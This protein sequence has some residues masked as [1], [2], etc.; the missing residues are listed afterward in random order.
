MNIIAV[1]QY[2]DTSITA[3]AGHGIDVAS[4]RADDLDLACLSFIKERL[5]RNGGVRAADIGCGHGGQALRMARL[6]AVV[7]CL[8]L[9]D[10]F[11]LTKKMAVSENLNLSFHI[12]D[13]L[14]SDKILTSNLTAVICQRTIHYLSYIDAVVALQNVRSLLQPSAKLFLSASG[15]NSE[16]GVGYPHANRVIHAR[17]ACLSPVVADKH[18]IHEPVCL[19][20]EQ[21][22]HQLLTEAGFTVERIYTSPFGN[23]KAI[24]RHHG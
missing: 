6:G 24:A 23:I 15:L 9:V 10:Q 18:N 14:A 12:G 3:G 19:Y 17:Q 22:M 1:N 5:E 16:L 11:E 7:D 13:I 21:D 4:Q 2:G 20:T 8:D